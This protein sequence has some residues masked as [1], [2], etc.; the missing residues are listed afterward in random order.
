MKDIKTNPKDEKLKVKLIKDKPK[1]VYA[2]SID[3]DFHF[4]EFVRFLNNTKDKKFDIIVNGKLFKI[5][6]SVAKSKFA[7][8]FKSSYDIF[9]KT[10]TDVGRSFKDTINKLNSEN[11]KLKTEAKKVKEDKE[12][13]TA[14]EAS[15]N[16]VIASWKD[17]IAELEDTCQILRTTIDEMKP[18]AK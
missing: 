11:N 9:S 5:T 4:D 14:K 17:R 13:F 1:K 2:V 7:E 10:T 3:Y 16:I 18:D 15:M 12:N 8:G 6:S